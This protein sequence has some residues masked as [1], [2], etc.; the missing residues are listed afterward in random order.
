MGDELNYVPVNKHNFLS[1]TYPNI[2]ALGDASNIPASKAG[3][4]AHFAIDL[5]SENFVNYVNGRPM[6]HN[7]MAMPTAL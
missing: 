3:S 2:F 5:F 4:V 6:D 7:L 1:D